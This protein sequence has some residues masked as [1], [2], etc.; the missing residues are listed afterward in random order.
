MCPSNTTILNPWIRDCCF[1]LSEHCR[2]HHNH[3]PFQKQ[4]QLPF[5]CL[6]LVTIVSHKHMFQ[7]HSTN[8][9]AERERERRRIPMH[10]ETT[11][12]RQSL[13][14]RFISCSIVATH[15]APVTVK[16]HELVFELACNCSSSFSCLKLKIIY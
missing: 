5:L 7:Q 14:R 13:P 16:R 9:H 12:K 10:I 4:Q 11:P 6:H 8:T 1:R 15:L 3:P 2:A